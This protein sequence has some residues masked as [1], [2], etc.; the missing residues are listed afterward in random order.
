MDA[1]Q[2]TWFVQEAESFTASRGGWKNARHAQFPTTDFALEDCT[3]LNDWFSDKLHGSILPTITSL[4]DLDLCDLM[5]D[6]V[7]VVKYEA[8][9]NRQNAL[10]PHYDDTMLSFSVLLSDPA[11][12]FQGGGTL[13]EASPLTQVYPSESTNEIVGD[14]A[15]S[16]QEAGAVVMH[17][18]KLMHSGRQITRGYRYLI[19]GF[20]NVVGVRKNEEALEDLRRETGRLDH[21]KWMA[22]K[23]P[24]SKVMKHRSSEAFRRSHMAD[25]EASFVHEGIVPRE[26]FAK[27][28]IPVEYEVC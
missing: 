26:F 4:Y 23:L 2:C 15:I 13:F 27:S 11:T 10:A 28:G 16:P 22:D 18:G 6:D 7:F 3:V 1:E 5:L 12:D 21:V 24:R 9:E 25:V 17:C 14:N 19:V 20:V 8:G